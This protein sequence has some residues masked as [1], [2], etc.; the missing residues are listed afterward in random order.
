MTVCIIEEKML[1][2]V[3]VLDKFDHDEYG[4]QVVE[5]NDHKPPQPTL[6]KNLIQGSKTP[7]K[8]APAVAGTGL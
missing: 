4:P 1:P 5:Q 2:V 8:N 6:K 3:F 7:S